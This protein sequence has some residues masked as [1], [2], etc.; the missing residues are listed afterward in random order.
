MT[1]IYTQVAQRDTP[2]TERSWDRSDQVKN[3]AGGYVFQVDDFVRLERFLALG[4]E[5][6]TYYAGE[7]K[8]TVDNAQAVKRAIQA[9]G[10]RVVRT[11]VEFRKQN[12]IPRLSAALFALA[13]CAT[14]GATHTQ[15][16]ALT[17]LADVA[18]TGRQL[19]E[20][21][22]F[23]DRMR[24]WGRRLRTGVSE[25]YTLQEPDN[26]LFQT[27]K[28]R[29]GDGWSHRDVLRMAHPH[30]RNDQTNAVLRYI[31]QGELGEGATER[32]TQL[33]SAFE[34][35]QAATD[36][37]KVAALVR[38]H[39][40][41][42][43]MIPNTV[44]KSTEVWG[45]LFDTSMPP[46]AL[47][48]NLA[49][50]TSLGFLKPMNAATNEVARRFRDPEY[51]RRGRFHPM[52]LYFA[53]HTYGAGISYRGSSRW[54]P[55][56]KI[57]NA[58]EEAF[59]LSFENVVPTNKN[60]YYGVDVSGSM[61]GPIAN[62]M[63]SCRDA[64]AAMTVILARSEPNHYIAG[65]TAGELLQT[66]KSLFS[67]GNLISPLDISAES[68]IR[69]VSNYMRTLRF[70]MTDCALP[71][72][73]AQKKRMPVDCFVILTDN[74]TYAG[75]IHVHEALQ[76]YRN[77]MGIDSRL[78]AVAMNANRFSVAD[79]LD[80]RQMDVVGFDPTVPSLISDFVR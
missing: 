46:I 2:Q 71:I 36:P 20:F 60:F 56:G 16:F 43:E 78:V 74:Q 73:D 42:R 59:R 50:M 49:N 3:D 80:P 17:S 25:W 76:N 1:N 45:A 12:R 65:F 5:G 23:V 26:V 54:E 66:S 68:R 57:T 51:V 13:M 75:D 18:Q 55:I 79:P 11:I 61:G 69:D 48:R 40:L 72:L 58:L 8:H 39:A 35:V 62:S 14:Y 27:L 67:L 10:P 41:P 70:G 19:L 37:A 44:L 53:M 31:A 33:I 24:G 64:A 32:S 28:Y 38:K 34:A 21:V 6:G 7:L 9:D 63:L 52:Q 30:A 15:N 4:S 29:S 47:M 77:D 22:N